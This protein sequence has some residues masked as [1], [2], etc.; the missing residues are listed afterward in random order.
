MLPE[1]QQQNRQRSVIFQ[2]KQIHTIQDD[3]ILVSTLGCKTFEGKSRT[4]T[5][6]NRFT[7]DR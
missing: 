7:P 1:L 5:H 6:Q 3:T 4:T 2:L